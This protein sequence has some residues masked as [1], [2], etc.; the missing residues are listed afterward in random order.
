MFKKLLKGGYHSRLRTFEITLLSL[1]IGQSRLLPVS[2]KI[3][4]IV[5]LTPQIHSKVENGGVFISLR[6]QQSL[7]SA[8]R[9]ASVGRRDCGSRQRSGDVAR[10]PPGSGP[11]GAICGPI[12]RSEEEGSFQ[13]YWDGRFSLR[14]LKGPFIVSC[15]FGVGFE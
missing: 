1:K 5:G 14:L 15:L 10:G 13:R 11:G 2:C 4:P 3:A 9:L 8:E 7:T 6:G 12:A